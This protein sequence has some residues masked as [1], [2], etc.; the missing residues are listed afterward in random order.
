M[1]S[2]LGNYFME[3][4]DFDQVRAN[5]WQRA[6]YDD[7]YAIPLTPEIVKLAGFELRTLTLSIHAIQ[8][9]HWQFALKKTSQAFTLDGR[10]IPC[11]FLQKLQNLYYC[12]TGEEIT[13]N[14]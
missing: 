10:E 1:E 3:S 4:D 11:N 7:M 8:T 5:T 13:I 2:R 6:C 14:L 12:H 9:I